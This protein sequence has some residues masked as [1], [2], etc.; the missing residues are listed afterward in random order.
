MF[1]GPKL[2]GYDIG[3]SFK[4]TAAKGIKNLNARFVI[5]AMHG[6]A[7]NRPCQLEH[8]PKYVLGTGIEDF[9]TCERFFSISNNCA[10]ISR[11]STPFHR[12]Q[13]LDIHFRDSDASH[14]LASG[15]FIHENYVEALK[16]ISVLSETFIAIDSVDQAQDGTF[17][18]YLKAE[19]ALLHRL[20]L[21]P[22]EDQSRYK[23]VEALQNFW[24]ARTNLD[25]LSRRYGISTS[26]VI[27]IRQPL[28]AD[29]KNALREY[30]ETSEIARWAERIL[31][32][33]VRWE[34]DSPEFVDAQKWANERKYRLAL[35]RLERLVIQRLF[36][37]QKANLVSTGKC[38]SQ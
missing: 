5:P 23:Y 19:A 30:N 25:A 11:Y 34:P 2:I 33:E 7:H 38:I 31:H 37:L 14:R 21:E 15:K 12:H 36:E 3:C 13:L 1:P 32:I 8:H 29:V 6:Y 35:D 22:L 4:Q 17:E 28:P 20:R 26:P 9:E 16:R 18:S 10:G 24:S 27:S